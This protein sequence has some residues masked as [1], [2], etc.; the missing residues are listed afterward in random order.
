MK[1][2]DKKEK[3]NLRKWSE[4]VG[5]NNYILRSKKQSMPA[6]KLMGKAFKGEIDPTKFPDPKLKKV[7]DKLDKI[8][9]K[10]IKKA[11][12]QLKKSGVKT[13]KISE[14][15]KKYNKRVEKILGP[16]AVD[17]L[18]TGKVKLSPEAMFSGSG[19][20]G[21]SVSLGG[22][23]V[24]GKKQ[25][26][27]PGKDKNPTNNNKNQ[28]VDMGLSDA[29]RVAQQEDEIAKMRAKKF[30][31]NDINGDPSKNI[32]DLITA[33]YNKSKDRIVSF[34]IREAKKDLKS[35]SQFESNK[36]QVLYELL[37]K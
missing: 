5:G 19:N 31:F 29:E 18:K 14:R 37:G 23:A 6:F 12:N 13:Y 2:M 7:T 9:K 15:L 27:E 32:F 25:K 33:R 20:G 21:V 22:A 34:D 4:Q 8:N 1:P 3:G 16:K 10:L 24:A 28:Q 26:T 11:E 30:K 35:Q 36:K 17:A